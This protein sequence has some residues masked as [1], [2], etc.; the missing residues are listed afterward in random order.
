MRYSGT[1]M[2]WVLESLELRRLSAL[3]E[4]PSLRWETPRHLMV[5]ISICAR[6]PNR[7]PWASMPRPS[8][9]VACQIGD[10]DFEEC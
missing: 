6:L 2:Q 1:L 4:R 3:N 5:Q 10:K 9:W 7:Q 8:L